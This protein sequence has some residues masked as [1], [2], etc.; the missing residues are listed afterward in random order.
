MKKIWIAGLVFSVFLF[1]VAYSQLGRNIHRNKGFNTTWDSIWV[2]GGGKI[3]HINVDNYQYSTL[4][5]TDTLL[6]A[7]N[8]DTASTTRWEVMTGAVYYI[9]AQSCHYIK[10]RALSDTCRAVVDIW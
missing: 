8:N 1:S 9:E 4:A 2:G 7:R 6:I 5:Y 10:I 3:A